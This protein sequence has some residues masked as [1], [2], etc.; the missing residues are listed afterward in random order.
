MNRC[1]DYICFIAWFAG[2]SYM[3]LWPLSAHGVGGIG[4][5]ADWS[6]PPA[7]HAIGFSAAAW[8]DMRL[9]MIALR[10]LRR[11]RAL[12]AQPAI[13]AEQLEARLG[14]QRWKA[15]PDLRAVKPRA[16]FGLRGVP[17]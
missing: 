3:A 10:H 4:L 8:V 13:S 7:L 9:A 16:Q 1:K 6:L 12:P 5:G 15:P 14:L 11:R 17:R 2:L